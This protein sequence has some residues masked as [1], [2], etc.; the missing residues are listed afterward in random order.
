MRGCASKDDDDVM[1]PFPR[2]PSP[3]PAAL[4]DDEVRRTAAL[5]LEAVCIHGTK[6]ISNGAG[7]NNV[8]FETVY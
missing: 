5:V 3:F 1:N 8:E 6:N 7:S 4:L 2:I